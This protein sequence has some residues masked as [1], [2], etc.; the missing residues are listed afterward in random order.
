MVLVRPGAPQEAVSD[1]LQPVDVAVV[2]LTDEAGRLFVQRR[3]E[4]GPLDGVWEFPGGRV[5]PGENPAQAA[6]REALEET[7]AEVL[8]GEILEDV[9][10]T[11]PDRSVRIRFYRAWPAAPGALPER[12]GVRW[13]APAELLASPIPEANRALI[14]RLAAASGA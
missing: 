4:D 3:S 8:L 14:A 12:D 5:E 11:Y 2:V 10:H 6:V 7:G 1:P 9:E 13:A